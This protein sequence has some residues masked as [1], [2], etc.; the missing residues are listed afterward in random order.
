MRE[1]S[2]SRIYEFP[3]QVTIFSLFSVLKPSLAL[4][5][6]FF[7]FSRE[8]GSII[9]V[10][11]VISTTAEYTVVVQTRLFCLFYFASTDTAAVNS[12]ILSENINIFYMHR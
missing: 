6:F 7:F 11:K 10:S 3:L 8:T 4:F 1:G 2:L 12:V 9:N 5:S